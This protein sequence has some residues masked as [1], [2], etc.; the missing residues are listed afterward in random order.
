[1]TV[2][3]SSRSK[4]GA[5]NAHLA[6][7]EDLERRALWLSSWTIHHANHIRES[8][9]GLKVG[10]HQASCASAVTLLAALYGH[11]LRPEDRIA[12]K[13]H[14]APV[15]H[16]LMYLMGLE[17]RDALERFRAFGGAQS[18]PSRTKDKIP[19]D[20]STGSV[21]LGVGMTLFASIAQDYLAAHRLIEGATGRMIAVMGDAE[22]DEGNVFE[23]LLEGW[24]HDVRD[25]WWV[26]DYNRHSLDGVVSD[27]L[28]Q[29][30]QSFFATVGWD[31]VLLKYGKRLEDAFAAPGGGA[32]RDWIDHCPNDLYSALTF[33]GGRGFRRELE[34]ALGDD[35]GIR[36]LLAQHDDAALHR[37]MT[38]LGGHDMATLVEAFDRAAMSDEPTCF[39]AYTIK[40]FGL[41]FAGHKDNHAGLMTEAQMEAFRQAQGIAPGAEWAKFGGLEEA[42]ARRLRAFVERLPQKL[43]VPRP[44]VHAAPLVFPEIRL[45]A[46]EHASTQ[47]GFGRLL[48]ELAK[49]DSALAQRVVTTSPDV[50]VSTNLGGWV[51]QTG[52]FARA[53]HSDVFRDRK[54]PSIQR[55]VHAPQGRHI[56]LGIAENNLFL[57]LAA[58]GL[59]EPMFGA[60]LLPIGTVYDPFIERGLDALNYA[61]YQDAR[62][63]LVATPS[64][65]SLAPEGG[66]HQSVITPLI[67]LGQPGLTMF[68]PAFVDELHAILGWAFDHLQRADGGSVYLRLSTRAIAQ[69]R[70]QL[71]PALATQ[72][73]YW[74]RP[75]GEQADLAIIAVGAVLPEAIEAVARLGAR[76]PRIGLM[77]ATSTDLLYRGWQA[78]PGAS[79]VDRLLKPLARDAA[80]VTV[81]D[82]HPASLAWLGAVR[83][84]RIAPLGIA[85]FGQSG[86]I[87]DLYAAYGI[88]SDAIV[89][90]A[91]AALNRR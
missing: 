91:E 14:A 2:Q 66:A 3:T 34:A 36:R 82:G 5:D 28:F 47:E 75:P 73:G 1:M 26:I 78:S 33:E 15:L 57:A 88:D 62:F 84:Q 61:C 27:K 51:N 54:L 40:G 81:T 18:Y 38:N 64:G 87:P 77:V 35:G 60:R 13:P 20:F 48:F 76:H 53:P 59:S 46:V 79:I 63:I 17:D 12:V 24:K 56:E 70:R 65:I 8:R 45:P 10:G 49:S 86:D 83:G 32:L 69:P 44:S 71:D 4:T 43:G 67:G 68:E 90:A 21:G 41:P 9:D 23:A 16:A 30:I 72:G 52:L 80:I 58:L 42:S 85:S 89:A 19:V 6:T 37:L 7:L 39:V 22:L 25:L 74:L 31:V 29:K 11:A 50:T 55:W